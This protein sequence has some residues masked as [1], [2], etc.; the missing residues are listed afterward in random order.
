VLVK[1]PSRDRPAQ[2]TVTAPLLVPLRA[3]LA[4]PMATDVQLVLRD[5]LVPPPVLDRPPSRDRPEPPLVLDRLLSRDR[6]ELPLVLDRLL[7]RDRPELLPAPDRLPSRVVRVLA[8]L[9]S[10]DRP[11]LLPAPDR[12]LSRVRLDRQPRARRSRRLPIPPLR[13]PRRRTRC[14]I[15]TSCYEL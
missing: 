8:R 7:S 11:E 9:L 6:P 5:R 12:L 1:P 13:T 2:P 15:P 3:R 14:L 10:R 4:Q